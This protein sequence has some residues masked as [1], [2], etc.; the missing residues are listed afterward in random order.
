MI[1]NEAHAKI[2]CRLVANQDPDRI[3]ELLQ[4]HVAKYAPPGVKVDFQRLPGNSDPYLMP[5]DHPGNQVT[6]AVL[7]EMYGKE[8]YYVRLGGSIAVCTLFLKE[9][10]AYT[11]SFGFAMEDEK[12]HAPNE[13]FRLS[14][15]ERGQRGYGML[16]ER[17]AEAEL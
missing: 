12:A 1:P 10:G 2:T 11:V 7:K 16:L 3:A 15:F 4:K 5:A 8:P 13:F 9:L 6:H 17:L 14:N